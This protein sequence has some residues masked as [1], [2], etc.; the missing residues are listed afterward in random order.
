M[1]EK[2][3]L[4]FGPRGLQRIVAAHWSECGSICMGTQKCPL[5][6]QRLPFPH[7]KRMARA[8]PCKVSD[9]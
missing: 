4:P 6:N 2:K 9:K 7:F 8:A 1:S 3:L 5:I